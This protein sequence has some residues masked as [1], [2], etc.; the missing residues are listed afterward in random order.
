MLRFLSRFKPCND[1][2]VERAI[3]LA[4][5][6]DPRKYLGGRACIHK[7]RLVVTIYMNHMEEADAVSFFSNLDK[8]FLRVLIDNMP[9]KYDNKVDLWNLKK[10]YT[11]VPQWVQ[12]STC[13]FPAFRSY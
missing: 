2:G 12:A 4:C 5:L 10:F 1:D 6:A 11:E 7:G 8:L 9:K 3:M 13:G